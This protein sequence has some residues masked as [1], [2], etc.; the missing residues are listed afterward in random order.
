MVIWCQYFELLRNVNMTQTM[1]IMMFLLL[2]GFM[3]FTKECFSFNFTTWTDFIAERTF[4]RLAL[5][6]KGTG[7]M[8]IRDI[9]SYN[10][11]MYHVVSMIKDKDMPGLYYAVHISDLYGPFYLRSIIFKDIT[12]NTLGWNEFQFN[13]MWTYYNETRS[14]W[15]EIAHFVYH[16]YFLR[17]EVPIVS[18]YHNQQGNYVY[19]YRKK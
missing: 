9:L 16:V 6:T 14:L 4:G 18:A 17:L 7:E 13:K 3:F 1:N 15:L 12:K 11:F 5:P 8:L 19:V 2:F 10:G